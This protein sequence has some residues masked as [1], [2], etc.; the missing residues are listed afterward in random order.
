MSGTKYVSVCRTRAYIHD[1]G[2][3]WEAELD[4]T[5]YTTA[6]HLHRPDPELEAKREQMMLTIL[7]VMEEMKAKGMTVDHTVLEKARER[8][9]YFK[10]E[11]VL[12]GRDRMVKTACSYHDFWNKWM[13]A[14][15]GR[16]P[17]ISRRVCL[18]FDTQEHVEPPR[19]PAPPPPPPRPSKYKMSEYS[20]DWSFDDRKYLYEWLSTDMKRDRK[21]M[22]SPYEHSWYE[23]E[24][25][26]SKRPYLEEDPIGQIYSRYLNTNPRRY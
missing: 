24:N 20:S 14:T 6:Y 17:A 9:E 5:D 3:V 18:L 15:W 25:N 2:K 10:S 19:T 23:S 4:S 16:L 8:C 21:Y 7:S 12:E 13:S 1:E 22:R 26:R 11:E